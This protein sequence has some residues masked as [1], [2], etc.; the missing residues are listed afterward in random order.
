LDNFRS[1]QN[2]E[3][4]VPDIQK[5]DFV[6]LIKNTRE[7]IVDK[8]AIEILD[9]SEAL[10]ALWISAYIDEINRVENFYL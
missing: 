3:A 1:F 6:A 5:K 8:D 9:K 2:L 10:T 7:S 4:L